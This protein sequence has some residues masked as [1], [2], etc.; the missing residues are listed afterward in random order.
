[1]AEFYRKGPPPSPPGNAGIFQETNR[2][3]Y[4]FHRRY[5]WFGRPGIEKWKHP[6]CLTPLA[7]GGAD[8]HGHSNPDDTEKECKQ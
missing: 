1:M 8:L 2:F 6:G 4:I 5:S 3:L 7:P